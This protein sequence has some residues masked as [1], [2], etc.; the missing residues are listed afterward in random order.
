MICEH[1]YATL[2]LLMVNY[3]SL[4]KWHFSYKGMG[5]VTMVL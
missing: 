4:G 3:H 5:M 1:L 2:I